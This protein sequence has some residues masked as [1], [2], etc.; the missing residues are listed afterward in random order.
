MILVQSPLIW[1]FVFGSAYLA[2]LLYW[3]RVSANQGS[4]I[5]SFLAPVRLV[6]PFI[7]AVTIGAASFAPFIAMNIA[8]AVATQGFGFAAV[9]LGGIL[10]PLTGALFFK[11]IWALTV[12]FGSANQ[13]RFLEEF[14]GSKMLVVLSAA[15][16]LLFAVALGGLL[17]AQ[18]ASFFHFLSGGF[19][20]QF[21]SI[22]L[23]AMM[24]MV[25][26]VAGGMRG[27]LHVGAI[28][29][30]LGA[31]GLAGVVVYIIILA[32]GQGG[33]L[34]GIDS[35]QKAAG[36]AA[37]F[38]VSGVIQFTSGLGVDVPAGGVL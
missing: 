12:R 7:S 36:S 21:Y 37:L 17:L 5:Q 24:L 8:D 20:S 38:N 16:A 34:S 33:L 9:S 6:S 14:Y 18:F 31:V 23:I 35:A 28:Q 3:A 19:F 22:V 4:A 25:Y 13:A 1:L 32:N 11:R 27:V 10:A 29:G 26:T 2:M 30:V 15:V